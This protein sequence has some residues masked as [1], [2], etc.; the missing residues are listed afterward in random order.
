MTR[1]PGLPEPTEAF[2]LIDEPVM[3]D[4]PAELAGIHMP[5]ASVAPFIFAVGFCLAFLGLITNVIILITGLLWILA[6]AIAWIRIGLLEY[7]ATHALAELEP[8]VEVEAVP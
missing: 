7:R 2:E 4:P 3:T 1:P 6:G 5:S 8:E